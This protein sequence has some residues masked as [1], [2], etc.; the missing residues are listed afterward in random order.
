VTPAPRCAGQSDIRPR[1]AGS[2]RQPISVRLATPPAA[3]PENC[4]R[5]ACAPRKLQGVASEVR[6]KPRFIVGMNLE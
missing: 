3:I 6:A 1:R 5:D 2:N 4:T